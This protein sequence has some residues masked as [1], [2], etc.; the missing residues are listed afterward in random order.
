MP[1][2]VSFLPASVRFSSFAPEHDE[3]FRRRNR[4]KQVKFSLLHLL[5]CQAVLLCLLLRFSRYELSADA[6][7]AENGVSVALGGGQGRNEP[8]QI[9]RN[10]TFQVKQSHLFFSIKSS[11]SHPLLSH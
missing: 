10:F 1:T 4:F 6:S 11:L 2:S 7:L 5:T 9:L 8:E 3:D